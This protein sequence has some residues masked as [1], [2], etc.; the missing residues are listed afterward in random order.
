MAQVI[1]KGCKA[2][3]LPPNDCS[4]QDV[5]SGLS[6]DGLGDSCLPLEGIENTNE[7][8]DSTST[9]AGSQ[10]T[11][12]EHTVDGASREELQGKD[13]TDQEKASTKDPASDLPLDLIAI[14]AKHGN[15]LTRYLERKLLWSRFGATNTNRA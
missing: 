3:D 5:E 8:L 6:V 13:I 9:F 10:K 7:D 14:P 11:S 15:K 1:N 12:S 4:H 2:S